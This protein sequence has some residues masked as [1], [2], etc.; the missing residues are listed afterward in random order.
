MDIN[1]FFSTS[2]EPVL[3]FFNQPSLGY[4]IPLYQR[5]YSWDSENID[6]LM[7]D[8]CSGVSELLEDEKSIH[9]MGTIILISIDENDKINTI[10]PKE[11]RALPSRIDNVIDGQQ[12]ISTIALLGCCLYE[13]IYKLKNKLK[14]NKDYNPELMEELEEAVNYFLNNLIE[15]FSFKMQL[16]KPK[17]KPIIIRGSLDNWTREGE[18]SEHYKSEISSYLAAFIQAL[19]E[20][21]ES[22]YKNKSFPKV[23]IYRN[24]LIYKNI[25]QIEYWLEKVIKSVEDPD[26][27]YPFA[28]EIVEKLNPSE[29]SELWGYS[30][31]YLCEEVKQ[32]KNISNSDL[33]RN[34]AIICS[35]VQLFTFTGYLLKRCCFT[36][37]KPVSE[38][39]A[40][41]MF[42]SLNATGTPL[43]AIETFK[44]LVVNIA[45][46][47]GKGFKDSNFD[48]Y[49]QEIEDLMKSLRSASS[50]NKNQR[51]NEYL[52]LFSLV[53]EG[54]SLQKQFSTQRNWLINK[55]SKKEDQESS[56][57]DKE[58][59]IQRMSY[60][61]EYCQTILY[62]QD[63]IN[64]CLPELTLV[65]ES[66]RKLASFC[67]LYL[68]KANHQMAHTILSRF[69]ILAIHH[70]NDSEYDQKQAQENF[71]IA[72]QV[73]T[74]F[75]TLWRSAL[76][77]AGLDNVYKNLLYNDISWEKGDSQLTIENLQNK[78]KNALKKNEIGMKETWLNKAI[79]YLR[80]KN[81]Q[82]V[83]RFVL[84]LISND[85][86]PDPYEP[87]LIIRGKSNSSK[88]Y[89]EPSQWSSE[90]FKRIEHIAPQQEQSNLE[91]DNDGDENLS[92]SDYYEKIGNLT[93]LPIKINSSAGD[94]QWIE[95]WIYYR[96]LAEKDPEKLNQLKQKAESN[97]ISLDRNDIQQLQKAS[98][99]HHLESIISIGAEGK[100][101]KELIERRTKRICEILW[102][103]MNEWLS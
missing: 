79:N 73:V 20:I 39:R 29:L 83:C 52:N 99:A 71:I 32:Y 88:S 34:Q 31:P 72:C 18:E 17:Y 22:K 55:F 44:P 61:A 66:K 23:P 96:H 68:K 70:Q 76:P 46:S 42:Q 69:Y 89:L 75:F 33:D 63:N 77:N 95:K 14:L 47:E 28:W 35:L 62:S 41:D 6:Q 82:K 38:V 53:Y 86:I 97:D 27:N 7:E 101:D 45:D 13:N 11:P 67:L 92:E 51:T 15:L 57:I 50:S 16:G 98:Y 87:G 81:V 2:S 56:L 12:R 43:T 78:F 93:L 3:Y 5:K 58:T 10:K 4:Y 74:A 25:Q 91:I 100:W 84:F 1:K 9:F 49:F 48:K 36:L 19:D 59:F 40:F 30:Y 102:E 37:I 94:K 103:R 65:D 64:N 24:S 54:K 90:D 80:Y 85:T 21:E 26:I 60:M 8:I